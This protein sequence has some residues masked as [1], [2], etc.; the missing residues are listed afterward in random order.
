MMTASPFP[1]MD[2]Y[3]ESPDIW[4][5]VHSTLINLFREQLNPQLVPHY[6]AELDTQLTIERVEENRVVNAGAIPDVAVTKS[7]DRAEI[8]GI[9]VVEA[10][11][12]P[13]RMKV[14]LSYEIELLTLQ[15]RRQSDK[16]LITAND[17]W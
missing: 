14:A 7:S 15:I 6:L 2:P 5:D 8:G 17:S 4:S 1:G 12:A 11:P 16:K 13:R 10:P 9:A 3:L